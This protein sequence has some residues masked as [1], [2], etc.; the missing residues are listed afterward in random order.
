MENLAKNE[1]GEARKYFSRCIIIDERII[2]TALDCLRAKGIEIIVAPYEADS[3]IGK[4]VECG[5]ADVAISED[6]DLLLYG[7]NMILKL[8]VNGECD[9]IDLK[10]VDRK[11]YK[12]N[13]FLYSWLGYDRYDQIRACVMAGCDYLDNVRGIGIKKA[14]GFIDL[15][16]SQDKIVEKLL[17]DKVFKDRVPDGYEKNV[18]K[19]VVLFLCARV[20]N[21]QTNQLECFSDPQPYNEKLQLSQSELDNLLGS[22]YEYSADV[23]NG[24][25]K[26]TDL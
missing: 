5:Y 22:V 9:Y 4:L 1:L 10:S 2:A 13:A 15:V 11:N 24:K 21:P 7:V 14:I 6:S 8:R 23:R 18:L 16:G 19:T 12:D 25:V 20:Y 3:Q 26:C 17:S